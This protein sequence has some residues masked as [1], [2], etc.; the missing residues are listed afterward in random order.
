VVATEQ[1]LN[2]TGSSYILG[3]LVQTDTREGDDEVRVANTGQ[4]DFLATDERA[5]DRGKRN[6]TR[7]QRSEN[8][9]LVLDSVGSGEDSGVVEALEVSVDE[10]LKG[11]Q[12]STVTNDDHA[13]VGVVCVGVVSNVIDGEVTQLVVRAVQGVTELLVTEGLAVN[14][15]YEGRQGISLDLLE[16]SGNLWANTVNEVLLNSRLHNGTK[17]LSGRVVEVIQSSYVEGEVLTRAVRAK[18]RAANIDITDELEKVLL[19]GVLLGG[20]KL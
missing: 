12:I 3:T 9:L 2:N 18:L 6:T 5:G 14:G 11:R 1:V 4:S 13:I 8:F 15:L 17:S 20:Q 7:F 19:L 10:L 16:F